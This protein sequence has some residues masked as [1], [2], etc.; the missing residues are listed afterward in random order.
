M[1]SEMCIRDRADAGVD[2]SVVS[3]MDDKKR[4]LVAQVSGGA[5]DAAIGSVL[6]AFINQWE[7]A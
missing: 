1:G 6:G 5:D 3:V 4:G 2:A 7:R